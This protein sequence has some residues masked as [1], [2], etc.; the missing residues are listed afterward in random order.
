MRLKK[1]GMSRVDDLFSDK[2][3]L[4]LNRLENID[5]KKLINITYKN[6]FHELIFLTKGSIT[7]VMDGHTFKTEKGT[8]CA[9]EKGHIHEYKEFDKSEGFLLRYK[10][11]FIPS[12][13]A[14]YKTAFYS[15]FKGN[16][17]LDY[18][19]LL[20]I[21][22]M[23]RS[24]SLLNQLEIEYEDCSAFG[25]NMGIM[26]HLTI[27]LILML[28]KSAST[29]TPNKVSTKTDEEKIYQ[30]FM[31][32]LE[33]QF[34]EQHS[35][36][37]YANELCISRRKLSELIK[38]FHNK[39]AKRLHVER[40]M[41]EAKRLLAYSN[42]NIKQ[43]AYELGFEHAPYFSNKFKEEFGVTPNNYRISVTDE[44]TT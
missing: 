29:S 31:I 6:S 42:L 38:K 23:T 9:L 8:V 21:E 33:E 27:S 5:T 4:Y 41:L 44:I 19:L 26:Q 40:V 25:V 11:E 18:Q 13:E 7:H 2:G 39:T 24:I 22:A 10:S 17:G 14:S 3:G 1:N 34:L 43:I 32:I 20:S 15:I 16:L 35:M 28:E 30:S 12:A 37:Y 36:T